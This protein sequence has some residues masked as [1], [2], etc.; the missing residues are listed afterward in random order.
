MPA[1]GPGG[2]ERRRPGRSQGD[3]SRAVHNRWAGASRRGR[4]NQQNRL[5]R[6]GSRPSRRRARGRSGHAPG[7]AGPPCPRD[8]VPGAAQGGRGRAREHPRARAEHGPAGSAEQQR[9]DPAQHLRGWAAVRAVLRQPDVVRRGRRD[10]HPAGARGRP[11][12]AA[13][14]ALRQLHERAA[15]RP[16]EMGRDARGAGVRLLGRAAPHA[17]ARPRAPGELRGRQGAGLPRRHLPEVRRQRRRLAQPGRAHPGA[18]GAQHRPDGGGVRAAAA[19]RGREP[20]RVPQ[21]PRV[22]GPV[23]PHRRRAGP[24]ALP[25]AEPRQDVLVGVLPQEEGPAPEPSPIGREGREEGWCGR[26]PPGGGGREPRPHVVRRAERSGNA[27]PRERRPRV[28]PRRQPGQ[29]AAGI[30]PD[31][32]PKGDL[33]PPGEMVLRSYNRYG[34]E[35]R[36]RVV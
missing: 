23:R 20:G 21:L 17:H 32:L 29:H 26:G 7:Q 3:E 16:D 4:Q 9:V 18:D 36:D 28:V 14:G 5:R 19:A 24:A 8:E 11:R 31:D 30:P 2:V 25:G 35:G 12:V 15:A 34:W 10:P 1:P 13:A 33:H 6:R 22:R 27:L